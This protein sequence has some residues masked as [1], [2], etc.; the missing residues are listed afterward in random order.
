[1]NFNNLCSNIWCGNNE[2]V[3]KMS[4][5][6]IVEE[7]TQVSIEVRQYLKDASDPKE[8]EKIA[9]RHIKKYAEKNAFVNDFQKGN[10]TIIHT[11]NDYNF[12]NIGRSQSSAALRLMYS[13]FKTRDDQ[14]ATNTI[15]GV[16]HFAFQTLNTG[17]LANF[18]YAITD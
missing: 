12:T 6:D 2:I 4:V 9:L 13:L 14:R 3:R 10:F 15:I 18:Q 5:R 17:T 16:R 8:K 1:M 7:L 11:L